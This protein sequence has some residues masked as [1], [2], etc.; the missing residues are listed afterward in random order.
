MTAASKQEGG[1]RSSQTT[2]LTQPLISIITVAFKARNELE[3]TII[4]VL[5]Q[6]FQNYEHIIIDGNSPDDTPALLRQYNDRL[7]YWLS[8]PDRGIYDAM[9]KGLEHACGK[10]VWFLNAG[11]LI[12]E[13]NTLEAI[14][15]HFK[16]DA[17]VVYG[18]AN[19][20]NE[21]NEILGTRSEL[22]T[23]KLPEQLTWQSMQ[24]GMV[25]SHQS[26]IIKKDLASPYNTQYR[27]SADID[28]IITILKKSEK[29]VNVHRPISNYLIG[30]F[31][32]QREKICWKERFE[33][34]VQHYGLTK[35][36]FNHVI[37]LFRGIVFSFRRKRIA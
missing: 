30:G 28:W 23:R 33:V 13:K 12:P 22:T 9:N 31:S 24:R 2:T 32:N 4:N 5:E 17:D 10:Y 36:L 35:T 6:T 34:Y 3:R 14:A 37:I 19:L 27:C 25:V 20:V 16:D 18:E 21:Q 1:Y 8:E 26:I 11:D 29:V 15:M 7:A